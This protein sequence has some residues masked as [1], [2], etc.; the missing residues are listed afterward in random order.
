MANWPTWELTHVHRQ[1]GVNNSIVDNAHRILKGLRP[2][3]DSPKPL[4]LKDKESAID[5]LKWMLSDKDWRFAMIEVDEASTKAGAY[6][7][8]MLKLLKNA[9]FYDPNR[10]AVITAINGYDTG[11]VG[12]ALGQDTMNRQL[13]MILNH[14]EPRWVLDAG[15]ARTE[16]QMSELQVLMGN[17]YDVFCLQNIILAFS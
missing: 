16:E 17:P 7:R 8:E 4:K 11:Q 15:R 13:S 3:S 10:D 12:F 14:D 2:I 1:Q 5:T 6:I 9:K